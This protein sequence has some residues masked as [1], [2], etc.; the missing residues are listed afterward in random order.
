MMIGSS[1]ETMRVDLHLHSRASGS[2]TNVWVKGLGDDG[3]VRESYTLPEES[4]RMAKRAGMDFVTLTDHE[5]IDGSLT[6]LHHPDFLVGEEVSARFPEDGGYADILL[7]GLDAGSHVEAQD[8]RS[9]LR[10]GRVS[11][12]SRDRP[13]AGASHV[14]RHQA[15]GYGRCR[16]ETC[17][18][19]TLGVREWLPSRLPEPPRQRGCRER[20]ALDLRQMALRHGLGAPDHTRIAGTGGSDDHGG[21]Y[22]G[23]TFTLIPRVTSREELLEA[24]AAGE[25]EP[26]GEDGSV[27]KVAHTAFRLAGASLE[28]GKK[29]RAARILGRFDL[30]PRVLRLLSGASTAHGNKLL[31]YVPILAKLDEAQIRSALA[32]RYEDHIAL[33]LKKSR[34]GGFVDGHVFISPYIAAHGYFG[35]ENKK[36]FE[37]RDELDL[38]ADRLDLK[39]GGIR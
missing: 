4:Y 26:D 1:D 10:S 33:A 17:A 19:R 3:D 24:L 12:G 36:A 22:G 15:T 35:R 39:I 16:E 14:Q 32:S 7:Y 38:C 9:N 6:L 5:T 2:A 11:E 25:S 37:L 20:G 28:E 18:L 31:R 13:R 23:S 29:G 21:I 8:R 30:P 27:G 34:L